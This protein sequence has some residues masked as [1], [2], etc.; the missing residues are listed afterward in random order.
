MN[1]QLA[2]KKADFIFN[3]KGRDV[4]TNNENTND[5]DDADS[6]DPETFSDIQFEDI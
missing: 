1:L 3:K 6:K 2:L 4:I 5:G